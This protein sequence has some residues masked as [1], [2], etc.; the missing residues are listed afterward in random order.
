[1]SPDTVPADSY[2][3]E[4][5]RYY[6]TTWESFGDTARG[7]DWKDE[8]SRRLRFDRI[9]DLF[10][11]Q[12]I[13]SILDVG[14]GPGA[15]LDVAR[16]RFDYPVSYTGVDLVVAM[17]QAAREKHPH[18]TFVAGDL[19]EVKGTYDVVVASGIFNVRQAVAEAEWRSYVDATVEA[20]FARA[21][22]ACVF[23]ILTSAVDWR[24]DRLFYCNPADMIS[25]YLPRLT[26]HIRLDHSYPL[27][28]YTLALYREP[29]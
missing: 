12:R 3:Q 9:L 24:I 23:N 14:C 15:F 29:Q 6:R 7:V 4:I 16:E 26:R 21:R 1:M 2:G 11:R 28:E 8:S 13:E 18:G 10:P 25:S 19:A 22:F 5:E 20:M 17:I 27:Y